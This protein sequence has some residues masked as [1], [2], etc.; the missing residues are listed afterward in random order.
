[1]EASLAAVMSVLRVILEKEDVDLDRGHQL[2]TNATGDD[3]NLRA[4][5]RWFVDWMVGNHDTQG[6]RP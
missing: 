5:A 1:M 3:M 6:E 2:L 4:R